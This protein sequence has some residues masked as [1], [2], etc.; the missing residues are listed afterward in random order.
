MTQ[1]SVLMQALAEDFQKR[2]PDS[3]KSRREGLVA[4]AGVILEVRSANR[5]AL[6]TGLP[7]ASGTEHD[8]SHDIERQLKNE[9]TDGDVTIQP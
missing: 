7:R 2:H 3:H 8:R 1:R 4:L 5:M 6:A 9:K